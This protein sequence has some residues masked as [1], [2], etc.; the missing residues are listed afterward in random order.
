MDFKDKKIAVVGIAKSGMALINF[1][2]KRGAEI[3]ALDK[4]EKLSDEII[5]ELESL[6]INFRLGDKYL[7]EL[8]RY[9]MIYTSPGIPVDLPELVLAKKWG[10]KISSETELFF[11]LCPAKIIGITGTNGKT[12]TTILIGE[13]LKLK[14]SNENPR[15]KVWVGGNIGEPLLEI[16]EKIKPSDLVV[17]ELSSFQLENLIKS[18]QIS[19]I[20]NI[21]PDHL[22][23][24]KTMENYIGAK[25]NIIRYQDTNNFAILNFDDPLTKKL[26]GEAAAKVIFFSA[27]SQ[28]DGVYIKNNKVKSQ[29]TGAVH[30]LLD[31]SSIKIPGK[32]NL[33][34]VLAA[35]AVADILGVGAEQIKDVIANFIGVEHRI[36]FVRELDGVKYYND[37]KATTPDSTI[38][39]IDAFDVPI[40]LIAGG[41][42]KNA[43]FSNLADAIIKKVRDLVLIGLTAPKM[44]EAVRLAL[45][46]KGL[47]LSDF[48]IHYKKTFEEAIRL[49]KSKATAGDVVLLS[50]ACASFDMFENY[51]KR[52][53]IFKEIVNSF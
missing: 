12:T 41:S 53:E 35:C 7:E 2:V 32:H 14:A 24:H 47:S 11:E 27:N 20:T 39:A 30:D 34:N 51:E 23:R 9:E 28:V 18:P 48:R 45:E 5:M 3:T 8:E 6:K 19:V 15:T 29:A 50:P 22:D 17:L 44:G 42:E 52:G 38:A 10:Q 43:D 31:V 40:V 25:T 46:K 37:S 26:V 33:S 21:T 36:E 16:V 49:A 13:L 1:L 4:K